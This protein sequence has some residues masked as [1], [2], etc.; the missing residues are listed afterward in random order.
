VA[1]GAG[2]SVAS[3][4]RVPVHG[5]SIRIAFQKG[6]GHAAQPMNMMRMERAEG[7]TSL[8]KWQAFGLN[9]ERN[10]SDLLRLLNDFRGQGRSVAAYGAPAKGNT[11]LNYCGIGVDMLPWTVDRNPLKVGLYTPGMHIPVLPVE[12]V[13]EVRPDYLLV[14]PWNFAEEIMRQQRAFAE[15]GGRF[16][17]PIPSPRIA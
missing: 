3:V 10:R 4:E 13:R 11:L 17:L 15:S 1:E 16:I 9:A 8:E 12:A 2:L 7:L 5:G 14:L 6:G